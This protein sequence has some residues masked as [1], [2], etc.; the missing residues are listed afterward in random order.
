MFLYSTDDTLI[1]YEDNPETVFRLVHFISLDESK[2][3]ES[4]K[5]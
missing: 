3:A 4:K 5:L 1:D 2:K